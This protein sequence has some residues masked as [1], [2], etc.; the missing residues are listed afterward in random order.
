VPLPELPVPDVLD[1]PLD[2]V[3]PALIVP[4]PLPLDDP[5]VVVMPVVP[6]EFAPDVESEHAAATANVMHRRLDATMFCMAAPSDLGRAEGC[7]SVSDMAGWA[8]ATR[9][10]SGARAIILKMA[11]LPASQIEGFRK[12]QTS[13]TRRTR[14]PAP[15]A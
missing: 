3:G 9:P 1:A 10:E 14:L 12:E 5:L 8:E 15:C 4:C 7:S 13:A 6:D 11:G 2:V